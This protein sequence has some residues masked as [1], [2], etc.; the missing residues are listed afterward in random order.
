MNY[1]FSNAV[2]DFV[3]N[4]K[5]R[6]SEF[7]NE[8]G[9]L[10]GN[11]HNAVHSILWNLIGSHDTPR[12]LHRCGEDKRRLRL[13]AALQMLLPGMPMIYYG[14]ET[15]MTGAGD[16]DCRRGMAWDPKYRDES[17][18]DWYRTLIRLRKEN[19]VLLEGDLSWD[20]ND[21][22][23]VIT[24]TRRGQGKTLVTLFHGSDGDAAQ[25]LYRGKTDLLTG[26]P[27]SGKLGPYET[28]VIVI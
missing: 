23:G 26:K 2:V 20:A 10:R 12:F 11:Y 14:D 17:M 5:L 19:P 16:P 4:R 3:A 24:L 13:A 27:F 1:P 8:L 6:P 28:A 7:L 9:F 25:P 18:T 15:A 21:S 22:T